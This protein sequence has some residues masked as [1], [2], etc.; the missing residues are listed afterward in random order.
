MLPPAVFSPF[1]RAHTESTLPRQKGFGL[2][3]R[4]LRKDLGHAFLNI[5]S[6]VEVGC[7]SGIYGLLEVIIFNRPIRNVGN[8][9]SG[10]K[11]EREEDGFPI[12]NVGND[13]IGFL[14]RL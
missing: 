8:G 11:G 2:A 1:C 7:P 5:P 12:K 9:E 14:Q 6:A 4:T 3:G 10:L 13:E